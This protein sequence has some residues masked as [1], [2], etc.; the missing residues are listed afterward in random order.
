MQVI[1]LYMVYRIGAERGTEP[2]AFTCIVTITPLRPLRQQIKQKG[3]HFG[4]L[5][6]TASKFL[7]SWNSPRSREFGTNKSLL[8]V[9]VK[10]SFDGM[11]VAVRINYVGLKK[12]TGTK[13][14]RNEKKWKFM[15]VCMYVCT[16]VCVCT[17]VCI[18][19]RV[20]MYSMYICRYVYMYVCM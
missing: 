10:R 19:V 17:T 14:K 6:K 13:R 20:C 12:K 4:P 3:S 1:P 11:G 9:F 15:Y 7:F 18:C 16:C 5:A 8:S 2:R